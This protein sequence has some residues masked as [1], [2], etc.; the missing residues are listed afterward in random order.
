VTLENAGPSNASDVAVE[1]TPTLPPGVNPVSIVPSAGNFSSGV[2]SHANLA[3]GVS[4][5]LTV[6]LNVTGGATPAVDAITMA[7]AVTGANEPLILTGD[8]SASESTSIV[9][10]AIFEDGFESGDTS[11]WSAT[12][13][14]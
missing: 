6:T 7:A 1:I 5:T 2:W 4:R 13:P 12:E 14:P 10:P 9:P 3:A 8:D 11:A